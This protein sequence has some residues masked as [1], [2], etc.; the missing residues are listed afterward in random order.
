MDAYP[1]PFHTEIN[2]KWIKD[3]NIRTKTIKLLEEKIGEK[4][5]GIGF[6]NDF[7]N[8]TSKAQATKTQ[9]SSQAHQEEKRKHP[10]ICNKK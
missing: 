4:L 2:L 10:N 5:H 8:T 7:L 9:T 1:G 3:L 6:G